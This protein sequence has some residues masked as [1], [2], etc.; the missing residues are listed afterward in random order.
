MSAHLSSIFLLYVL[1]LGNTFAK[2]ILCLIILNFDNM[3]KR[4]YLFL[5]SC[6]YVSMAF[7]QS[8]SERSWF[9][10]RQY[11]STSVNNEGEALVHSDQCQP[12]EIWNPRTND[13]KQIGG[14]GIGR[15]EGCC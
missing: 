10:E 1:S 12:I 11:F 2:T 4:H 3:K 6:C 7:A 14:V 15:H 5:M 8:Q 9:T 13:Y